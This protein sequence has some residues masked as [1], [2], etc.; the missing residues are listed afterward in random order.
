MPRILSMHALLERGYRTGGQPWSR[1]WKQGHGEVWRGHAA[2]ASQHLALFAA[3]LDDAKADRPGHR[4]YRPY[5][6][7]PA[8]SLRRAVRPLPAAELARV[9]GDSATVAYAHIFTA[10]FPFDEARARWGA[11]TG[12]IWLA[13]RDG[14][15]VGF[16]AAT[17]PELDALY[18]LPDESGAGLGSRLLG[19]HEHV[20]RLWVLADNRRGRDFYAR[21][22]WSHCGERRIADEGVPELRY[23]RPQGGLR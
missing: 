22:G 23:V 14:E 18:V 1:L 20:D 17:G 9:H 3:A 6:P 10:P 5:V 13:E 16:A 19:Q 12:E 15:L 8:A 7:R 2:Y 11:H 21:R 4:R